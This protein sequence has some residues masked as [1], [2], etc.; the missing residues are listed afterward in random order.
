VGS[1]GS[2]N[3]RWQIPLCVRYLADGKLERTCTLLDDAQATVPLAAKSCPTWLLANDAQVGYYR[4][5][6]QGGLLQRLLS[7]EG[8]QRLDLPE[9]IGVLGDVDA[10]VEAGRLPLADALALAPSLAEDPRRL[11]AQHA[12]DLV[13][14]LRDQLV[15]RS[16][17]SAYARL[18]QK[19]FAARAHALGWQGKPGEDEDTRLLRPSLLALVADFG[20]DAALRGEA[21]QLAQRWLADHA[22]VAPDVIDAVLR[23]AAQHGDQQLFNQFHAAVAKQKDRRDRRHLL[24]ALGAFRDPQLARQALAIVLGDEVD[25]RESLRIVFELAAQHETRQLAYDFVKAKW[26]PLVKRLPPETAVHLANVGSGF[27][28]EAHRRDMDQFFRERTGALP[29]GPRD[30]AQA[31]EESELCQAYVR[32]QQPSAADFLRRW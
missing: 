12:I 29:G 7:A 32:T 25:A 20:E 5:A 13:A 1:K 9:L 31:I 11:V 27:C 14:S 21:Q 26:D 15:P 28:D 18:I 24:G 3:A 22:A 30:F 19:L 4:A 17:E 16:L 2:T 23:V 8:K 6:Y 10:L